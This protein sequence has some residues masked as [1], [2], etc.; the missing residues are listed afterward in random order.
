MPTPK[1][2][3]G[4][5]I[6]GME[7]TGEDTEVTTGPMDIM[8][9]ATDHTVMATMGTGHTDTA[10]MVRDLPMKLALLS[11]APTPT[12]KLTPGM[13]IMATATD[14][15]VMVTTVATEATT[16]DKKSRYDIKNNI[17]SFPADSSVK[18]QF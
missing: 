6:T 14:H 1:P 9:T 13:D 2:T 17:R 12:P 10:T 11:L 5:D 3:P 18:R 7:A 4:M 8:A 16:G 15:T